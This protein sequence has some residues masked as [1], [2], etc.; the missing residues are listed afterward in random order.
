MRASFG[1]TVYGGTQFT[2]ADAVFF[3]RTTTCTSRGGVRCA[4]TL[5]EIFGA[6][7]ASTAVV[8]DGN[9]TAVADVVALSARSTEAAATPRLR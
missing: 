4:S 6:T 5:S 2:F 8:V 9:A 7:E 3:G 1:S